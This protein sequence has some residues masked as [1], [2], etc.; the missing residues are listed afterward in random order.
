LA[1]VAVHSMKPSL[2]PL[3][4][5]VALV[6]TL[7]NG[8]ARPAPSSSSRPA[9]ARPAGAKTASA[10][11]EAGYEQRVAA[12]A[13][14][15]SGVSAELHQNEREALA[16]FVAAA[17]ADLANEEVVVQV[18]GRLIDAKRADEAVDLL[19]RAAALPQAGGKVH[20]WL[21][22]AYGAQGKVDLA[23]RADW[24]AIRREPLLLMAYQHLALLQQESRRPQDALRVLDEAAGQPIGNAAFFLGAAELYGQYVRLHPDEA[25]TVKPRIVKALDRAADLRPPD[26]GQCQRL[27]DSYKLMAEWDKAEALYLELLKRHP[28]P[29]Y[30]HEL[31]A[32]LYLRA[33]KTTRAAEEL[34]AITRENPSHE[35]ASFFLGTIA[36]REN[37]Y[38]EA[39]E[40]FERTLL[41]RPEF[42]PA[43]FELAGVKLSLKKP[44][45]ALQVIDKARSRFQKTFATEF[46]AGLAHS[47]AKRYDAAVQ[48]LTEAEVIAAA[49]A[50]ERLT[51]LLY[52]QLGAA[53]ERRGDYTQAEKHFRKCLELSPNFDEA[54]NYLGYMWADRGEN[55]EEA[56]QFIERALQADPDNGA[57]L[58]SLGWVL[59][60]LKQPREALGW[61]LQAVAKTE[62]ADATLFEHLGDV[63][64]ELKE[65]DKARTAWQ[66]SLDV[67]P[68]DAVK[69]RLEGAPRGPGAPP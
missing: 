32:D 51:H 55:L 46:Y 26:L 4:L 57:Y 42:E 10:R 47:Q 28:N 16:H 54:L 2:R 22:I 56:R 13:H 66:K 65:W 27:A 24:A 3:A 41:L 20:A 8:C 58:D 67:E 17:T 36:F 35:Q 53:C 5:T 30:M 9:K 45:E 64:A 62:E 38:A 23:I 31:L 19:A 44:D 37:Q 33:G 6:A 21:A 1:G 34:K 50:P 59:F 63:H 49:S 14:F 61:L 15:A 40:L 12:Y 25:S 29:A 7:L 60:K 43:Y 48:C 68:N 69:A 18:A 52:F 11:A 39:E